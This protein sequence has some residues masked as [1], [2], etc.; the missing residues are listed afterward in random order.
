MSAV[1]FRSPRDPAGKAG[2][3]AP[4]RQSG[5]ASFNRF[6]P[7]VPNPGTET[8]VGHRQYRRRDLRQ[9]SRVL[10]G[11]QD[12][13]ILRPSGHP[14]LLGIRSA[15]RHHAVGLQFLIVRDPNHPSGRR[16]EEILRV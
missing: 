10:G 2:I 16:I 15:I 5:R 4:A 8:I 11:A 13:D 1:I 14:R 3:R 7:G 6:R 9:G 12:G